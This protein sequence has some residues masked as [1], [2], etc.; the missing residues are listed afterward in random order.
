MIARALAPRLFIIP[1]CCGETVNIA[2]VD[3]PL[4]AVGGAFYG[5]K[6][7]AIG[8]PIAIP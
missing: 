1:H 8:V 2:G 3:L 7:R 5:G 6:N 4:P